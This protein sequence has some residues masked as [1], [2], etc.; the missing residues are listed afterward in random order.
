MACGRQRREQRND[1]DGSAREM[2][3]PLSIGYPVASIQKNS[4]ISGYCNL[5]SGYWRLLLH[6]TYAMQSIS[7]RRPSPGRP[8]AWIVVRA[9]RWSPNIRE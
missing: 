1:N 8:A 4:C 7:T 5:A 3:H 9:G 2:S 6:G